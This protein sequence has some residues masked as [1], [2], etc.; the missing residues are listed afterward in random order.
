MTDFEKIAHLIRF[1]LPLKKISHETI[2]EWTDKKINDERFSDIFLT[3]NSNQIIES[4]SNKVVWDFNNVEIRNLILSYYNEYL[5]NNED[6]WFKIE[7]ELSNYFELLEYNNSNEA[8]N[9]F[10]YILAD[11]ISL[12]KDGYGNFVANMPDYLIE[13]LSGHSNYNKLN[14]LLTKNGLVGYNI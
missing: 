2:I 5:K 3:N 10:L 4:F 9:D 11:D 13:N 8:G 12:R 6:K 7:E 14:E 1:G